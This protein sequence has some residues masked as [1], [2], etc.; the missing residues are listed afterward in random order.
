MLFIR[1]MQK[2]FYSTNNIGHYGLGF[3]E[4]THFT[5]PIR[6]YS[7]LIVHRILKKRFKNFNTLPDSISFC[8]SGEL[9]G[10]QASREYTKMKSL[11]WLKT[12]EDKILHGIITN[13]KPS[14]I[15]LCEISTETTGYIETRTLPRDLYNLSSN[16]LTLL[17][18]FSKNRYDVG[19]K[20]DI[21]IYKID[22][23]NQHVTFTLQ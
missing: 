18:K 21:K 8:N 5:S 2:A 19:K 20:I 17:G 15:T 1:K 23:L 14:L 4:Y 16:K 7:D 12:Q 10:K 13:I 6:R 3:N 22:L 9:K 11:R